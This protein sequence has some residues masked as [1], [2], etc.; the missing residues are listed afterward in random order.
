MA[1]ALL[2]STREITP[3]DFAILNAG[4]IRNRLPEGTIHYEDLFKTMPFDNYLV[5]VELTGAELRL[6]L[7]VAFSGEF[8]LSSISGLEIRRWDVPPG[9]P[10]IWDRDLNGDGKKQTWERNLVRAVSDS[11]GK[12]IEDSRTYRLATISFLANGGDYC[13]FVYHKLSSERFHK[14]QT[15]FIRDLIADYVSRQTALSPSAYFNPDRPRVQ[16]L[17]PP[18]DSYQTNQP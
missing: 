15:A 2:T 18:P 13:D 4:G 1:D 12:P 7:E 16:M 11:Q 5:I 3:A 8:G 9:V 17:P 10:G 6:L 14:F